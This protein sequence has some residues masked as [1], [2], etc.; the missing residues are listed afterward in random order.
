MR[1]AKSILAKA[2]YKVGDTVEAL[3]VKRGAKDT[4][5]WIPVVVEKVIPINNGFCYNLIRPVKNW[6]LVKCPVELI[7][8]LK[9]K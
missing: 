5:V 8:P 7:R 4:D 1:V 9:K 2:D 6:V 3:F